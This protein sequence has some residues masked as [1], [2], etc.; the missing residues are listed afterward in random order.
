MLTRPQ[1]EEARLVRDFRS[2]GED[3]RAYVLRLTHRLRQE[4]DDERIAA[5]TLPAG[6]VQLRAAQ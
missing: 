6:V 3:E 1:D 4:A 5:T 2:L